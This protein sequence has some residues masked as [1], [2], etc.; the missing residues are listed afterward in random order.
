MS[1]SSQYFMPGT[2]GNDTA[3]ELIR[4]QNLQTLKI[5]RNSNYSKV[6]Y[7]CNQTKFDVYLN[8]STNDRTYTQSQLLYTLS[9]VKGL[10]GKTQYGQG[11]QQY[12]GQGQGQGQGQGP[13]QFTNTSSQGIF[14]AYNNNQIEGFPGTAQGQPGGMRVAPKNRF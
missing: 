13:M 6:N 4:C 5:A 7:K 1:G 12:Y 8:N 2:G 3:G 10:G 11:G 14:C 9:N